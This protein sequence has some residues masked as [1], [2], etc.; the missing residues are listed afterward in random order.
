MSETNKAVV[1]RILS[2]MWMKSDPTVAD[3]LMADDYM[4]HH[5]G[6]SPGR[7]G[8]KDAVLAWGRAFPHSEGGAVEL[9]AEGDKVAAR[10]TRKAVHMGEMMGVAATGREVT[11]TGIN[12]Y[13][14]AGGKVVEEWIQ[15]DGLGLL[16]QLDVQ[17]P[18]R[19]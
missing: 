2:D 4:H 8:I 19:T 3:E 5:P 11:V 12:I 1:R 6:L 16:Q 13:R 9:V 10:W 18:A 14:L 17:P 15:F 7:Q